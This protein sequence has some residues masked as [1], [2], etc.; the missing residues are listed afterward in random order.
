M[1]EMR[2]YQEQFERV[3]RWY[4]RFKEIND[5]KL[6]NRNTEFDADDVYAF[7]VNCYHLKDWI[8]HDDTIDALAKKEVGKFIKDK[9]MQLCAKLCNC[10][11]KHLIK[12]ENG[13]FGGKHSYYRIPERIM[14]IKFSIKI[15]DR[16][17]DAFELATKCVQKW[18]KFIEENIK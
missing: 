16:D 11:I 10:E 18:E 12:V 8:L 14:K 4:S 9:D 2:K 13:R 15:K 5:G 7:F 17:I 6:H 3:K 1:A